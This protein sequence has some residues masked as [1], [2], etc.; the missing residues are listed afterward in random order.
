MHISRQ[1]P[2]N[3]P[4]LTLVII[5]TANWDIYKDSKDSLWA[6]PKPEACPSCKSSWFGNKQHILKLM[7][8]DSNIGTFTEAGLEM[9]N[10]LNNRILKDGYFLSFS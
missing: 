4:E 8:Q 10:G 5:G 1:N 2:V 7:R 6:Y 9:M 3:N